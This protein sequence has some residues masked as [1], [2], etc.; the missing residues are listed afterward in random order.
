MKTKS[1]INALCQEANPRG[2]KFYANIFSC[3]CEILWDGEENLV[4]LI[5]TLW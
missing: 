1:D 2:S 3:Y 5:A 4:Y